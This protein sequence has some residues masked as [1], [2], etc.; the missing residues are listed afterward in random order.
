MATDSY[1]IEFTAF[2]DERKRPENFPRKVHIRET[3]NDI[4]S[5]PHLQFKVND[6]FINLIQSSGLVVMKNEDEPVDEG[7]VTFNKR[8]F[9]PWHMI[10][11]MELDVFHIPPK[12]V[13]SQD[14]IV[15]PSPT[16]PAPTKELVN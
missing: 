11:H 12:Q 9:V 13:T 15:P 6:R 8:V 2:I 5:I 16:P 14:S 3:Y 1:F 4:E 7:K 10:T